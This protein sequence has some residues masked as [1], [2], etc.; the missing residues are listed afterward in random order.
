[1]SSGNNLKLPYFDLI[2]RSWKAVELFIF[3]GLSPLG[4]SHPAWKS[5]SAFLFLA[6]NSLAAAWL[7][8]ST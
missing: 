2:R 5:I 7:A 4:P 6:L 8:S 1:M 3:L